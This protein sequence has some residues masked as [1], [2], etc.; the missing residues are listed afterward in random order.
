M[1]LYT[2]HTAIN[3]KKIITENQNEEHPVMRNEYPESI[4]NYNKK[5]QVKLVQQYLSDLYEEPR[6][7]KDAQNWLRKNPQND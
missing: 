7:I 6:T 5:S 3:G 4:S 2:Y 1:K